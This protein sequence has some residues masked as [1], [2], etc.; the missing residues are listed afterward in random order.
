MRRAAD[1]TAGTTTGDLE[2]EDKL[3]DRSLVSGS[4]RH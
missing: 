2:T 1:F 4:G 3:G